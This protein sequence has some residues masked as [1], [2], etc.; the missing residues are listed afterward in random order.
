MSVISILTKIMMYT[1]LQCPSAIIYSIYTV[2]ETVFTI[3]PYSHY[4]C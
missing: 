3:V 1:Y 2:F 4:I